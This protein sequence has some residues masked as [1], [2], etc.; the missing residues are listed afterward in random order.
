[1]KRT[2]KFYKNAG[3][4]LLTLGILMLGYF[5]KDNDGKTIEVLV[6]CFGAFLFV[7]GATAHIYVNEQQNNEPD[8]Y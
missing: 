7:V 5:T 6:R 2:L 8:I 4:A 3:T 1:M